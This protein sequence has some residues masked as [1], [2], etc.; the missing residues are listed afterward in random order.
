MTWTNW[1]STRM[2]QPSWGIWWDWD[3]TV[4]CMGFPFIDHEYERLR[5]APSLGV[6]KSIRSRARSYIWQDNPRAR[7]CKSS[8]APWFE[9]TGSCQW[10][11]PPHL[12]D[13]RNLGASQGSF[14]PL[15]KK[16]EWSY[17]KAH[18]VLKCWHSKRALPKESSI[19]MNLQI[20]ISHK[21][22]V[23]ATTNLQQ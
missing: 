19:L 18:V 23:H 22:W 17:S 5:N 7:L 12:G 15:T 8:A 10:R 16:G 21:R 11:H 4:G 6:T 3:W 13:R 9:A 20:Y 1:S 2:D 14:R